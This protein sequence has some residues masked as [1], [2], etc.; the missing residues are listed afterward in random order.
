MKQSS[1][2]ARLIFHIPV[3]GLLGFR[4]SQKKERK[5]EKFK[6]KKNQN[7]TKDEVF[8]LLLLL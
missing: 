2:R 3:R 6:E 8:F 7:S 5:K 1:G 4:V